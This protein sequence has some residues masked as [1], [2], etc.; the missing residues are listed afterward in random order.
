M[1]EQQKQRNDAEQCLLERQLE[2]LLQENKTYLKGLEEEQKRSH[3]EVR[4]KNT[5][6]E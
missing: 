5:D 3:L 4:R 1:K 6:T 2:I